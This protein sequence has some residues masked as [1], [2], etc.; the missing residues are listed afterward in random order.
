MRTLSFFAALLLIGC[1]DY[2]LTKHG[3][4]INDPDDSDTDPIVDDGPQPDI[5][6]DPMSGDFGYLPVDC[7]SG[8][9]VFTVSN[10]GDAVLELDDI[11]IDGSGYSA[12][13][14]GMGPHDTIAPGESLD[15]S[16]T[17]TADAWTPY[18]VDLVVESND[19][20]EAVVAVPLTAVGSEDS[21]FE[22][23]F[24]QAVP[25]SV[26]VLWVIDNSGSMSGTV[27]DLAAHMPTFFN[28]FTSLG[29]DWQMGV[30]TTDMD[31]PTD[32]GRLQGVGV[33]N[34][35]T[36]DPQGA[37]TTASY[38]GSGGSATERGTDAAYASLESPGHAVGDGLVRSSGTL[39][40]ILISDESDSS[41]GI[42]ESSFISWLDAY[43]GDP[44]LTSFSAMAGPESGMMPCNDMASG[45]SAE[46][47]PRYARITHATDGFYT[48]LCDMDFNEVLTYLSYTA[49]GML[50]RYQLTQTPSNI[51]QI[52]VTVN[53][54]TVPYHGVHG[55]TY[56]PS[57][58]EIVFH[59]DWLPEPDAEI[60]VS[61]PVE[62][63]CE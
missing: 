23:R 32:Q 17:F 40:I 42:S 37:F 22:E 62:A 21:M 14:L 30:T 27:D 63:G 47:A 26:D 45:I 25:T 52:T 46:P 50:T 12:F 2:D 53:G 55:F 1:S 43:K 54:Y 38:V 29:L 9:L 61:Y 56:D 18:E 44:D 51:A 39:A 48:E 15:V 10:V 20:D 57:T 7:P 3:D 58:N 60:V 16:V 4:H 49:A 59:G 13:G 28:N 41:D 11:L 6:I 19:P 34:S 35:S 24:R 33:I 36:P 8:P 5:E 31:D